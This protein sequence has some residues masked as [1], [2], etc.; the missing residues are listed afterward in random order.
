MMLPLF[1]EVRLA[2]DLLAVGLHQHDIATI[3]E[4]LPATEAHEA[5]YMLEAFDAN[6]NTRCVVSVPVSA[7]Q[8][9]SVAP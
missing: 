2:T 5:G 7:V 1:S 4:W 8:P 9:L 3:V 6:G